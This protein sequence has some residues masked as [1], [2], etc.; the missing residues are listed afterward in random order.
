M[1]NPQ[2]HTHY[3]PRTERVEKR[4][5]GILLDPVFMRYLVLT[6]PLPLPAPNVRKLHSGYLAKVEYQEKVYIW[7]SIRA[8]LKRGRYAGLVA[9]KKGDSPELGTEIVISLYDVVD[10]DYPMVSSF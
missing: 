4:C 3:N 9:S 2:T 1:D 5:K 6:E 10:T 8:K 7:V